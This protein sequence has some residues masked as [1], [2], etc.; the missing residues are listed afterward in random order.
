MWVKHHL[1]VKPLVHS[2][3]DTEPVKV[4]SS[5]LW[6]S[7]SYGPA[8]P[9]LSVVPTTPL[10]WALDFSIGVWLVRLAWA[11]LSAKR[12]LQKGKF[13]IWPQNT[14]LLGGQ[15]AAWETPPGKGGLQ[16]IHL[17][18]SSQV[19]VPASPSRACSCLR[20]SPSPCHGYRLLCAQFP[21]WEPQA[22]RPSCWWEGMNTYWAR[23]FPF[24]ASFH[25]H[26]P[27]GGHPDLSMYQR[28]DPEQTI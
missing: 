11:L 24:L 20:G 1:E 10:R 15:T 19:L 3:R 28:W 4:N 27:V 6:W 22:G 17:E 23:N 13:S 2:D 18:S 7:L 16:R 12:L 21:G 14:G 25:P 8:H 26:K 5:S 9:V